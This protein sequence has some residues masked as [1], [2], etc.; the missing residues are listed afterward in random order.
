[1]ATHQGK[2]AFHSPTRPEIYDSSITDDD[3]P[4]VVRKKEIT[5]K[6]CVNDYKIYLKAKLEARALILHDVDETWVLE[7]KDEE[8]LFKQVTPIQL[9]SH[10]QSI[11]G[12][13]HA[14]D[15]LTLQNEMQDYHT[16]SEGILDYTN[17]LGA[18]QKKSKRGTGNNLITD[19]TLL[20]IATHGMFKTGTHPRTTNKWEDLD[21]SA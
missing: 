6:A 14:I 2:L 10:L 21:A 5:W 3:K 16:D 11:C 15:V 8:T 7:L 4:A 19:A 18:A 9:L 1:M 13:L 12:G 17:A 20:L